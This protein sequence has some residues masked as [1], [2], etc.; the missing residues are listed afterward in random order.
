ML[1][2]PSGSDFEQ[3]LGLILS[4]DVLELGRKPKN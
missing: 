2:D 3:F 1:D 4:V